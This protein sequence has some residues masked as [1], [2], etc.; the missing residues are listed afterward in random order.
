MGALGTLIF[1]PFVRA[2]SRPSAFY[3]Q[4]FPGFMHAMSFPLVVPFKVTIVCCIFNGSDI[5]FL[6]TLITFGS[7]FAVIAT[8]TVI[9]IIYPFFVYAET[10][11]L[12]PVPLVIFGT[13]FD[14]SNITFFR[15]HINAHGELSLTCFSWRR[16]FFNI[17]NTLIH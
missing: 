6:R 12:S 11:P 5:A 17:I 13:I 7:Q 15:W 14:W 8:C 9:A 1:L 10:F 16:R 2:E 3:A 4:T